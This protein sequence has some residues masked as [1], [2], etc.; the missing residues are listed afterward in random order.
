MILPGLLTANTFEW[1]KS[2]PID[3]S[4]N[5]VLVNSPATDDVN[6]QFVRIAPDESLKNCG[7]Y[8][9]GNTFV[10][11]DTD[12]SEFLSSSRINGMA[13]ISGSVFDSSGKLYLL[14]PTRGNVF[15]E[16]GGELTP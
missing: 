13:H 12:E 8:A 16:K 15:F 14:M 6:G 10:R 3:F 5:Y 11:F 7:Q 1:V 4:L 2:E 9:I